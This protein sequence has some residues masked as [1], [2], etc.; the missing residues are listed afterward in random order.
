MLNLKNEK[1]IVKKSTN[2]VYLIGTQLNNFKLMIKC[3]IKTIS[4]DVQR[5]DEQ[6]EAQNSNRESAEGNSG[7]VINKILIISIGKLTLLWES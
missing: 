5:S 3:I 6:I 1:K 7:D 4:T 2:T